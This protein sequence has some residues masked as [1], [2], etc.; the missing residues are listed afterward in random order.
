MLF[1]L[2]DVKQTNSLDFNEF[3][4]AMN[5][6]DIIVKTDKCYN[7]FARYFATL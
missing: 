1:D 7:L 3:V 4:S 2:F 5:K 6:M